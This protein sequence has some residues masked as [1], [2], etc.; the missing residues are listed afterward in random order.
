MRRFE[1]ATAEKNTFGKPY[2]PGKTDWNKVSVGHGSEGDETC[3]LCG[4]YFPEGHE[5]HVMEWLGGGDVVVL[6]CCGGFVDD[7][8][9]RFGRLFTLMKLEE[10]G[11]DPAAKKFAELRRSLTKNLKAGLVK[12][13]EI[14]KS[15]S[16]SASR[17][18][19][20]EE[21]ISL[22]EGKETAGESDGA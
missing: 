19:A 16:G 1:E 15:V 21:I 12:V 14:F 8:Y 22:I 18:G 17:A 10:F 3:C 20:I 11:E 4:T 6:E 7:L 9:R 13:D 2:G 5:C